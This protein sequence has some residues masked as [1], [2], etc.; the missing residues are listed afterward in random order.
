MREGGEE[1]G[2]K[3]ERKRSAKQKERERESTNQ[4]NS[5]VVWFS[6]RVWIASGTG[7]HLTHTG[8][9]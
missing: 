9:W 5:F 4:S 3:D 6:E 2:V 8:N 1:E 7:N